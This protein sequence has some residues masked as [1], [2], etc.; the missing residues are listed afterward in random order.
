MHIR[1]SLQ[2]V[3]PFLSVFTMVGSA[4]SSNA[5]STTDGAVWRGKTICSAD[6][7]SSFIHVGDL[8]LSIR[9]TLTATLGMVSI[10][11]FYQSEVPT[12]SDDIFAH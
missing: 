4:P 1:F 2:M 12:I 11:E 7:L 10:G 6:S 9:Y 8:S 5:A 3:I